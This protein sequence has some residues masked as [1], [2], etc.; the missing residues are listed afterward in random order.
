MPISKSKVKS[1]TPSL[2]A[3]AK[4]SSTDKTPNKIAAKPAASRNDKKAL[5][6][7]ALSI[8]VYSLAGK[9]EGEMSLPKEI[10]GA[11]INRNLLLQAMRVYM[12]NQK[13][14]TNATKGRGDVEGSTIKIYRQKGTG[15]ARHGAIRAPIFVGGGIVFGPTPRKVRLDLPQGMK[16]AALTSAL[17]SKMI[18]KKIIGLTGLE[19]ASGKTKEIATLLRKI[20][21]NS[22]DNSILIVIA[23]KADNVVRAV[24]N[25][26]QV[27]IM[28]LS[29][30]NAYE[31][32]KHDTLMLTKDAVDKFSKE[33]SK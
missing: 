11:K 21:G 8:P 6:S 30:I 4:Q 24:M 7:R 15:R 18:D 12:T 1:A 16:K 22:K 9:E 32:L 17:S 29:V 31:I 3:V 26:P 5:T 33:Q 13:I 19:K 28:P 10:F 2:R 14:F 20:A 23:E 25:I 27:H